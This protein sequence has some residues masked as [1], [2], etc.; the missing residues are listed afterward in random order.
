ATSY[1]FGKTKLLRQISIR[2][3]ISVKKYGDDSAFLSRTW[4]FHVDLTVTIERTSGRFKINSIMC[5]VG[6]IM[7]RG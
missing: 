7:T 5:I 6:K 2:R 1:N 3:R 4:E